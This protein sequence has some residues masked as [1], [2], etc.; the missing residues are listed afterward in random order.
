[1]H[2]A[3]YEIDIEAAGLLF[4]PVLIAVAAVVW[5]LLATGAAGRVVQYIEELLYLRAAK[6]QLH[7]AK[8]RVEPVERATAAVAPMS[9]GPVTGLLPPTPSHR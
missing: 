6:A 2:I 3:S 4:G 9:A 7:A 5:L 8:P 1:M